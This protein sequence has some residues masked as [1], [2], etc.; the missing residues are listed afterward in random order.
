[1]LWVVVVVVGREYCEQSLSYSDVPHF[2][3]AAVPY[4]PASAVL[5]SQGL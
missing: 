5:V 3:F 4:R 2:L 1:M